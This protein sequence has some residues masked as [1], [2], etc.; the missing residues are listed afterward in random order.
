MRRYWWVNHKQTHAQEIN[1][2][3]LWSPK[4]KAAGGANHFYNNMRLAAPG[5]YVLSYANGKIAFIGSVADFA[6]S[7]NKPEEFGSAGDAWLAEGW[8]LPVSW[9][10]L[11]IP[12]AP[13]DFIDSLGPLL[14]E[15][16][17]PIGAKSGNGHQGAYLAEISLPAFQMVLGQCGID[18]DLVFSSEE[19]AGTFGTFTE[20]IDE[21]IERQLQISNALSVTE[22][23][24]VIMARR[25]QGQ[26][27]AN[28]QIVEPR[29]R[30]TG[31]DNQMLLIASHIKP[32]RSCSNSHERLDGNNGLLLT[33]HVD[34]LF[35]RGLISF[36]SNGRILYSPKLNVADLKRLGLQHDYLSA[37]IAFK[38]AQCNY[39]HFHRANIFHSAE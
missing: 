28:V 20:Q 15:K 14:P 34:L 25:G 2:S 9:K 1:G 27:R 31:I 19:L 38:D 21:A 37:P 35:D 4:T 24:Q 10:K 7:S 6:I 3:Y 39:L 8:L 30:L 33:P 17:S 26:F 5:D 16:Y 23:A 22:K 36:E 11:S 32:W 13:K 12:V 29:C 18:L